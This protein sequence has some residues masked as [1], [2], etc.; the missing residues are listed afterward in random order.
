MT[1]IVILVV[2]HEKVF[3]YLFLST[4]FLAAGLSTSH[5]RSDW[6]HNWS[7]PA[8]WAVLLSQVKFNRTTD[9]RALQSIQR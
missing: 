5:V 4:R 8:K 7:L 3:P 1:T 2:P 6:L 9:I